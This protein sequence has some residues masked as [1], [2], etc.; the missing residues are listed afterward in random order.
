MLQRT[1][2]FVAVFLFVL[3][4]LRQTAFSEEDESSVK[5][6]P[7]GFVYYQ[8]GQI[9]HMTPEDK[10]LIEKAFD[11]HFNGRLTLEAVIQEKLRIIVGAEGQLAATTTQDMSQKKLFLLKEA[12]GIYSFGDPANYLIQIATG[13]FPFKYNPEASN[14]GEYLLRTGAYPGYV[15]TDFDFPKVRLMGLNLSGI[16]FNDIRLNAL[17]TSEYM[18]PPYFDYSLSFIAG[19]KFLKKMVDIGAGINFNRMLPLRPNITRDPSNLVTDKGGNVVV[20]DG[21]TLYYTKKGTKVM[22]KATF[23]PKPLL[24]FAEKLGPNDGK[25]YGEMAILGLKN[26]GAYYPEISKRM[27]IMFG[28][29]IPCFKVMDILSFEMEYYGSD[30]AFKLDI[31]SESNKV[32]P[33]MY[34]G[35][36]RTPWKWSIYGQKTLVK[37][38]ALKGLIGRDHYRSITNVGNYDWIERM[39]GPKDWHYKL[40]IMYSF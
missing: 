9:E 38:L 10:S 31:P 24:P 35:E 2:Y 36:K 13:Y 28:F 18:E 4:I 29:N 34:V 15:I 33:D 7:S 6:T 1:A 14:L 21:D 22:A 37:G 17:F 8:I 39:N 5:I 16:I 30:T 26:Y 25:I 11:Q 23:N 40:R 27:P 12:Q 3:L 32:A 19:Y 20:E